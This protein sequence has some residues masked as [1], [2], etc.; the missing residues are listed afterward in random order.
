MSICQDFFKKRIRRVRK[1][2]RGK[3]ILILGNDLISY[4]D[5]SPAYRHTFPPPTHT[6]IDAYI[7]MV[8]KK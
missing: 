6:H 3:F 2:K 5:T 4:L 7:R 8:S 1:R